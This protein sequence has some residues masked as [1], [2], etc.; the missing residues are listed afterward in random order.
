MDFRQL[1]YLVAVAEHRS[2]RAA[3]RHLHIAQPPMSQAIRHLERELG[4][5]LLSRSTRGVHLTARGAEFVESAKKI[6]DEAAQAKAAMRAHADQRASTLRVGLIAGVVGAA[7]LTVPILTAARAHRPDVELQLADLSIGDQMTPLVEGRVDVAIVRGPFEHPDVEV[8][9]IA[10]EPRALLVGTAHDLAAED[11]VDA[12]DVVDLP[13][14]PLTGPEEWVAYWQLDEVRGRPHVHQAAA[15]ARSVAEMQLILA[16]APIVVSCCAA[17]GRL[18]PNP[19]VACRPLT[20]VSESTIGVARRRGDRSRPV[21]DF[22][23]TAAEAATENIDLLPG[24][25]LPG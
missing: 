10:A 17:L 20:G 4:V 22:M 8:V 21:A 3:A 19:L 24:G 5:E 1:T 14:L 6:L 11:E 12:E 13:T 25:S 15:Q 23:S 9:P 2:I 16:S 7:E 18:A